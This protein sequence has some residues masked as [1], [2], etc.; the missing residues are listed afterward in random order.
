ML[1]KIVTIKAKE[2][3]NITPHLNK[4]ISDYLFDADLKDTI[5]SKPLTGIADNGNKYILWLG[6]SSAVFVLRK[7]KK[8]VDIGI[9]IKAR[10][11]AEINSELSK[12]GISLNN[13]YSTSDVIWQQLRSCLMAAITL[14]DTDKP[15]ERD[16]P[17]TPD[18]PD[19]ADSATRGDQPEL[20]FEETD[21]EIPEPIQKYVRTAE[22][23]QKRK[24]SS[25]KL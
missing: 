3:E 20:P 16:E 23:E 2:G 24:G 17:D 13:I 10:S 18:E 19:E 5:N 8:T 11:I 9:M 21:F 12:H 22:N 25:I 7:D 6:K 14:D 1:V 4:V 15:I